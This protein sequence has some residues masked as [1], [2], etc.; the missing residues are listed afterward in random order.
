[1]LR[2]LLALGHIELALIFYHG[3]RARICQK[4][5]ELFLSTDFHIIFLGCFYIDFKLQTT[6][7]R[8]SDLAMEFL[9]VCFIEGT[10][11]YTSSPAL[12]SNLRA[13]SESEIFFILK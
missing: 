2:A 8:L 4:Y 13:S 11:P 10:V 5:H 12:L 1:M 7:E 3:S 9:A 6:F